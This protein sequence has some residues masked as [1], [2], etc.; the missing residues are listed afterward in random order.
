MSR[1]PRCFFIVSLLIPVSVSESN[2]GVVLGKDGFI[3]MG[4]I[5]AIAEMQAPA[6]DLSAWKTC[7]DS[8]NVEKD[9]ESKRS[10]V[11]KFEQPIILKALILRPKRAHVGDAEG[12]RARAGIKCEATIEVK[13]SSD[14]KCAV[15]RIEF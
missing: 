10:V 15:S 13:A 7:C 6:W 14:I 4:K 2:I 11:A 5:N 8:P 9:R 12:G 3:P 1:W